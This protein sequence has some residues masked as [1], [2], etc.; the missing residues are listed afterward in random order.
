MVADESVA[1]CLL[2]RNARMAPQGT[3]N[4]A[5]LKEMELLWTF[6]QPFQW[7]SYHKGPVAIAVG[8]PF[9]QSFDLQWLLLQLS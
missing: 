8:E 7:L 3:Q 6:F 4:S 1:P 5:Q 2:A 9:R